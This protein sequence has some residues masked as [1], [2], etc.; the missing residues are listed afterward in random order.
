MKA[1]LARGALSARVREEK[2]RF[3]RPRKK[4]GE[5]EVGVRQESIV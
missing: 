1:S 4:A 2:D 3:Q 5:A